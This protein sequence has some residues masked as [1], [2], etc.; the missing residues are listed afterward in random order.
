MAESSLVRTAQRLPGQPQFR[1]EYRDHLKARVKYTLSAVK[2]RGGV[3]WLLLGGFAFSVNGTVSKLILTNGLSGWRLA[4]IRALGAAAIM[5]AF[6]FIK[7]RN[8]MKVKWREVPKLIAYGAIGIALVNVG[9]FIGIARMHVSIALIIEFTA[10]IWV[11]LWV[12]FVRR[13]HVANSMWLALLVSIFGLA[14]VAQIWQG[15]TLDLIG[16]I[17]SFVS[18]HALAAYLLIGEKIKGRHTAS[19]M[20]TWGLIGAA[21]FWL[22]TIPFWTFPTSIFST[23]IDLQGKL[24]GT[25]VPG[26]AII[27]WIVT[28]GTLVPYICVILGLRKTS[29]AIA[30]VVSMSEAIMAGIIAWFWLGESWN[31]IQL[32]GGALVISGIILAERSRSTQNLLVG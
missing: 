4:Q 5:I 7:K 1:F 27:L 6:M 9:Y 18:A 32:I 23:Q 17:A 21:I 20:L 16:L 29:A 31:L 24:A 25:L 11:A 30:G 14:I 19:A 10:P 15:L 8:E 28:M 13:E 26:W 12:K 22:V 2:N 3:F